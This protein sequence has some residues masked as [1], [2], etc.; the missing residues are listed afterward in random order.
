MSSNEIS[1]NANS[2]NEISRSNSSNSSNSKKQ[3]LNVNDAI[4]EYYKM[5]SKY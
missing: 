3:K 5:K 4:N 2:S 1:S